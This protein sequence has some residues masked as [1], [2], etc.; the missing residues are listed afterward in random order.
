MAASH[1]SRRRHH[2]PLPGVRLSAPGTGSLH[3]WYH[4]AARAPR[5]CSPLRV[6]SRTRDPA[7]GG[8]A[9]RCLLRVL[10]PRSARGSEAIFR[11]LP[12]A[13]VSPRAARCRSGSPRAYSPP[14]RRFWILRSP[15]ERD[16]KALHA[17]GGVVTTF[18]HLADL[19]AGIGTWRVTRWLPG[20]LGP[21]PPPLWM[22]A[23]A[24]QLLTAILPAAHRRVKRFW[25]RM[26]NNCRER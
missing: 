23:G 17:G 6:R 4:P 15:A 10:P 26:H 12:R 16:A 9:R 2:E 5:G 14:R 22:S 13:A 20:F 3:P 1:A 24:I 11:P 8:S 18:A 21:F 19:S 25:T 7:T